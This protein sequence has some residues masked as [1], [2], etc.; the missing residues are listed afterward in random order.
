MSHDSLPEQLI[1]ESIRKK[2]RSMHLSPQQLRLCV[3][4]YQGQYILKVPSC[5]PP[6]RLSH[7]PLPLTRLTHPLDI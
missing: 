5:V 1:A 6:T 3:Q 7:S 4:E 2:S